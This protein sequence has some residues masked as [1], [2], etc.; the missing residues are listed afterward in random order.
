VAPYAQITRKLAFW[1]VAGGAI[2]SATGCFWLMGDQRADGYPDADLPLFSEGEVGEVFIFDWSDPKAPK[3]LWSITETVVSMSPATATA[4]AIRVYKEGTVWSDGRRTQP[5]GTS[6]EAIFVDRIELYTEDET[7]ADVIALHTPLRVGTTWQYSD[8]SGT[9]TTSTI[10]AIRDLCTPRGFFSNV[11]QVNSL[12]LAVWSPR[13][14]AVPF[15]MTTYFARGYGLVEKTLA[16]PKS[17]SD[18]SRITL[19]AIVSPVSHRVFAPP[20]CQSNP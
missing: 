11:I 4:P 18:V 19:T 7:N 1:L 16:Q 5:M 8:S 12:R 6:R 9:E 20:P 15:L 17:P 2:V 14:P 3:P 10:A 13:K